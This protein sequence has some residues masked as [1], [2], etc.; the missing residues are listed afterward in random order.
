[1]KYLAF[2]NEC[3]TFAPDLVPDV[4]IGIKREV[5]LKSGAIPV[6]V[7]ASPTPPKEGL[8]EKILQTTV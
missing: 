3:C 1:L 4:T 8:K 7:R 2:E 6:A 5:R